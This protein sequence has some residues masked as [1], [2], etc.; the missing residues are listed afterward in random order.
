VVWIHQAG[1]APELDSF[2]VEGAAVRLRQVK[3]ILSMA[4]G[5][6]LSHAPQGRTV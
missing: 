2:A 6:T 1:G 3:V 4:Q 5:V